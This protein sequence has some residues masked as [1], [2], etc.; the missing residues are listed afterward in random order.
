MQH[1][2]LTLDC[3]HFYQ[4]TAVDT[5]DGK[6]FNPQYMDTPIDSPC[7]HKRSRVTMQ[8]RRTAVY[9]Q[10]HQTPPDVQERAR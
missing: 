7:C 10:P 6:P 3:G 1:F 9:G 4:V 5:V 2:L 8:E